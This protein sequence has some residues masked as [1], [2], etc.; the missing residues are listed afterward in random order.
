MKEKVNHTFAFFAHG[1]KFL[2][3]LDQMVWKIFFKIE[4]F[5]NLLFFNVERNSVWFVARPAYQGSCA[6]NRFGIRPGHRWDGVDRSNGYE[7]KWFE[8][9]NARTALQ[10]EAYKWS[11]A[12]MWIIIFVHTNSFSYFVFSYNLVKM[13]FIHEKKEDKWK[14]RKNIE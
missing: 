5:L 12:D 7:K 3:P 6:P 1:L 11:T 8:A 4:L 13:F 14:S 2:I 9:R 10:E